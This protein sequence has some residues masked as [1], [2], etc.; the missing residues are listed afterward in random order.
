MKRR[1]KAQIRGLVWF[2]VAILLIFTALLF[3][4]KKELEVFLEGKKIE[5][6]SSMGLTLNFLFR[7]SN[8]SPLDYRVVKIE[9][10]PL[11]NQQEFFRLENPLETPIVVP[12]KSSVLINVPV[13]ITYA[14]LFQSFPELQKAE[15][16]ICQ[17]VGWL[18]LIDSRQR[19]QKL[20]LAAT[21]DFPYFKDWPLILEALQVNNLTIGGADLIFN[22]SLINSQ[23]STWI[24]RFFEGQIELAGKKVAAF[25]QTFQDSLGPGEG[26][27]LSVPLLLDFF[28]LGGDLQEAL[29]GPSI[30]TSL[31]GYLV[32]ENEWGK[33]QIPLA[34][35]GQLTILRNGEK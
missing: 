13:K 2:L 22:F 9:T 35:K 27:K 33:F 12:S 31:T 28:E 23:S 24:L 8:S 21:A 20:S 19:E 17:L 11:I 4:S 34:A 29:S 18:T 32:I 15:K 6:L 10:R 7:I 5:A 30:E 1:G 25:S 14:Y 16:M 26:K 3:A